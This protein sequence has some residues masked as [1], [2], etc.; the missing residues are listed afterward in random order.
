MSLL[1]QQHKLFPNLLVCARGNN[2]VYQTQRLPIDCSFN[3][4]MQRK[5]EKTAQFQRTSTHFAFVKSTGFQL[6]MANKKT[7]QKNKYTAAE[8]ILY[9]EDGS[10]NPRPNI[11]GFGRCWRVL[12]CASLSWTLMRRFLTFTS[13]D[14]TI[15]WAI[16]RWADSTH[17]YLFFLLYVRTATRGSRY[18]RTPRNK[19]VGYCK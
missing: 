6:T 10:G 13:Q 3:L 15:A 8:C 12:P 9:K 2:L 7:K 4:H 16:R 11:P 18:T 1:I 14:R 17:T 5:K 19:G